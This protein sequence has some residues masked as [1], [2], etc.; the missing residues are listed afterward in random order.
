MDQPA[1]LT[2][3]QISKLH[4]R[5]ISFSVGPTEIVTLSG[6]SG[7]GKSL[8]L[9]CISDLIEHSGDV[10]LNDVRSHDLPAS[11]WRRKVGMLAAESYWW[12]ERMGDHFDELTDAQL[13]QLG[14]APKLLDQSVS[15]CS[16]GER[17]RLALL[18]LLQNRPQVLL[19]D[20]PTSGLDQASARQV[21]ELIQHYIG[22]K[23]AAAVWVSHDPQ[24]RQRIASRHFEIDNG[25]I[26]EIE[27]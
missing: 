15:E 13:S 26:K 7:S 21:E 3:K 23:Q 8:L 19:L 12:H 17:Q 10:L 27:H 16:T 2:L 25:S 18:R 24:Q 14:L 22:E 6:A 1:K 5:P 9:R 4:L 11:Q 20:E